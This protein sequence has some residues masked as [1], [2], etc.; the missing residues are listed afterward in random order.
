MTSA[1]RKPDTESQRAAMR[2]LSFLVGKWTGE[3]SILRGAGESIELLQT[4]EA[5]YKLDGLVL[6]IEGIG[7]SKADGKPALQ[8][9]G[10]I[11]YDDET[12]TYHM[13]AY[14]DGRYLETEVKLAENGKGMMWVF[15]LGEIKTSSVLQIDELGDW[16]ELHEITIGSQ[17]PRKFMQVR[18]SRREGEAAMA[19]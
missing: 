4:E 8:A 10:T 19:G 12:Q 3:A 11:S 9:L 15:A 2:K 6:M 1:P 5:E 18:A 14:N 17:P 7:R 16:T 13:R